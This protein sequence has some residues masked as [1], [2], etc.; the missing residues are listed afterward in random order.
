MLECALLIFGSAF[1]YAGFLTAFQE[2]V[3]AASSALVGIIML[4]KPLRSGIRLI[5]ELRGKRP[6]VRNFKV[7]SG[8]NINVSKKYE[9]KETPTYH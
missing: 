7:Y 5:R 4:A 6:V 3:A 2:P 8:G 9:E 1:V